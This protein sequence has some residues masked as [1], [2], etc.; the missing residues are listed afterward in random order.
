MALLLACVWRA[1]DQRLLLKVGKKLESA[2]DVMNEIRFTLQPCSHDT[3]QKQWQVTLATKCG[4]HLAGEPCSDRWQD[5]G[6]TAVVG[7]SQEKRL[8]ACLKL[9]DAQLA[10]NRGGVTAGVRGGVPPQAGLHHNRYTSFKRPCQQQQLLSV[11]A[12]DS[13]QDAC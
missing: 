13:S 12:A 1:L 6:H 8:L 9:E 7:T 10:A 2:F 11:Q 4:E 3:V 5:C